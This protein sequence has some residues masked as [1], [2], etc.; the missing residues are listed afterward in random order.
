VNARNA[1]LE[2]GK[3]RRAPELE[4]GAGIGK[5][6][7]LLREKKGAVNW[8]GEP[9][10]RLRGWDGD[11]RNVECVIEGLD[12]SEHE[13]EEVSGHRAFLNAAEIMFENHF[14]IQRRHS[15]TNTLFRKTFIH[16]WD[17]SDMIQPPPLTPRMIFP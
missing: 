15:I 5:I 14:L 3:S 7:R 4:L 17:V 12:C 16:F 9:R 2:N 6:C 1:R 10:P 8:N 11:L 13:T